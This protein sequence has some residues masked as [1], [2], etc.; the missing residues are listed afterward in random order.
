MLLYV[1]TRNGT[2]DL[3]R[4]ND[5]RHMRRG[6]VIWRWW[7]RIGSG[8]SEKSYSCTIG[9]FPL[10]ERAQLWPVFFGVYGYAGCRT[11]V[12]CFYA[13][14]VCDIMSSL[15]TGLLRVYSMLWPFSCAFLFL[16]DI[17]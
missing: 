11:E 13:A 5:S 12:G 14:N 9:F 17:R 7:D 4:A 10:L 15:L 2:D 3:M 16:G 8:M 6:P 1:R